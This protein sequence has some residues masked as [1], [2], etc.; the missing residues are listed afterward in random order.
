M[1]KRRHGVH[2]L[3]RHRPGGDLPRCTKTVSS[4]TLQ[5]W[6]FVSV[7]LPPGILMLLTAVTVLTVSCKKIPG[8]Q[9][10]FF[11]D[12][13]ILH[14]SASRGYSQADIFLFEDTLTRPCIFHAKTGAK[15]FVSIPAQK[16]DCIAVALANVPGNLDENAFPS[17]GSIS[18]ASME[19]KDDNPDS[20]LMSGAA[21]CNGSATTE[22]KLSP[23][24]CEIIIKAIKGSGT[25]LLSDASI[26]L[27]D[28]N[29]DCPLLQMDGFYPSRTVMSP[30]Q[31]RYPQMMV[32]AVP[33]DIGD[34]EQYA[35]IHLY[36]YP[37]ESPYSPAKICLG[38]T[39]GTDYI[40]Y[41]A[42]LPPL[43]RGAI[44]EAAM[45]LDGNG[46]MSLT[47]KGFR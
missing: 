12:S 6:D 38:A 23:L 44:L 34:R 36:C 47:R 37:D 5:P 7:L 19:Y 13:L 22:I 30:E 4:L 35:D 28:I 41:T 18:S 20:P 26:W 16:T 1:N 3:F 25:V 10:S 17:F 42:N 39:A 9:E 8:T 11:P 33:F 46:K 27:E 15:A 40:V 14:I 29:N 31:L 32:Q 43:G 45:K 24:L 2:N 21:W